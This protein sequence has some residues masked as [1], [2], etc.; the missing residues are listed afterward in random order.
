MITEEQQQQF[1]GYLF[2][3][4]GGVLSIGAIASGIWTYRFI[5]MASRAEGTVIKLNAGRA[6]PEIQFLPA[7][8]SQPVTFSGSGSI[9]YGIGDKVKV[10]YIKDPT[11]PAGYSY[12][13]DTPGSL[14][15]G[16]GIMTMLGTTFS[17]VG[18]HYRS[19]SAANKLK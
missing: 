1:I 19:L 12:S 8:E 2:P 3:I 14:W 17:I 15:F 10:L 4:I 18:W 9:S 16:T 5:Q 6:H 11:I 7:G 13:V